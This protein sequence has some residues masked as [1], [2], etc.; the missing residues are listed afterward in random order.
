MNDMIGV[1]MPPTHVL[2]TGASSGLGA[3]LAR[4]HAA[5]GHRLTL[6]GRNGP[7][8][9]AVA[10]ACRALG[11]D[12]VVRLLDLEDPAGA[13]V[14]YAEDDARDP[15]DILILN[16]GLPDVRA[17]DAI[18]E[19]PARVQALGL[20]NYVTSSVLA[21][22]AVGSMIARG[23]GKIVIV[24][25]VAAFHDLPFGTA[26][27]GSKAGIARFAKA[28]DL[29]ARPRG[30]PVMLVSPGFIDTPMSQRLSGARPLLVKPARAARLIVEGCARGQR[31][32]IFPWPFRVLRVIDALAP[33]WLRAA[34]LG[35]V[36]VDQRP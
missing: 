14:G 30:V 15:V 3:A 13:R 10:V 1:G 11:A 28:L 35:S 25:S 31:H 20:V 2:I 29:H 24:G 22:E 17:A 18:A 5:L 34:L 19:D 6:W 33:Y 12:V 9:E 32:L 26:Y 8:L 16:A 36:Q 21:T 7:R 23:H 27:S 4:H